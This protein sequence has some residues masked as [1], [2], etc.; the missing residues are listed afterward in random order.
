MAKAHRSPL[1]GYNHNIGHLGRVFHVQ[2]EDSGPIAPRVFTHLFHEGIILVSRKVEYET[3]LADDKVRGLMQTQ[4]RAVI[5]E[6]AAGAFNERIIAFFR[7]RGVD[8]TALP[9]APAAAGA[10]V[11]ASGAAAAA[12]GGAPAVVPGAVPSAPILSDTSAEP[13]APPAAAPAVVVPVAPAPAPAAPPRRN[14][15]PIETGRSRKPTPS[16][17]TVRPPDSRRPP[18]VRSGAPAVAKTASADGVV[19]QRSVVVGGSSTGEGRPRIRPPVPYI[20]TGGSHPVRPAAAGTT[21]GTSPAAAATGTVTVGLAA[22][23]AA[24]AAPA[25]PTTIEAK[26]PGAAPSPALAAGDAP[27]RT[28]VFGPPVPDDKSLDEVILEYLSEDGE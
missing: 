7:A 18:F 1:L 24:A 5:K 21:A 3:M 8:L 15:R 10:A 28:G 6:L 20:V 19:V 27:A 17:V 4:H 11:I 26:V 12:I 14:T 22:G 16:P 9:A 2:T 13:A 25:T 23:A